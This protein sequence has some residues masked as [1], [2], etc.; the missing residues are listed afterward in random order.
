MTANIRCRLRARSL[1][2]HNHAPLPQ[3]HNVHLRD[4][5]GTREGLPREEDAT[6]DFW[7]WMNI[8]KQ[9]KEKFHQKFPIGSQFFSHQL[10][11]IAINFN[12]VLFIF[13]FTFSP[14]ASLSRTHIVAQC[15]NKRLEENIV[16]RAAT[17]LLVS[18]NFTISSLPNVS[19]GIVKSKT[20]NPQND[21]LLISPKFIE[22]CWRNLVTY[23]AD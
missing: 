4:F 12:V 7:S 18:N 11:H 19:S 1:K 15:I 20:M 17:L 22:K 14:S 10:A 16:R 5:M 2:L 21:L 8:A 6:W 23:A 13:L 9:I 3:H